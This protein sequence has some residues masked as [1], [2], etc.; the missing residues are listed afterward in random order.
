MCDDMTKPT[1]MDIDGGEDIDRGGPSNQAN[2][3]SA[4]NFIKDGL[5]NACECEVDMFQHAVQCFNCNTYYHA[6]DCSDSSYC[7]SAKTAYTQHIRPALEKTGSYE[8]RFGKFFFMCSSCCTEFELKKVV[9]Q[10]KRVDIIDKKLDNFR[11]ELRSE[12]SDLKKFIMDS[13]KSVIPISDNSNTLSDS[14]T[15]SSS[16]MENCQNP[17]NYPARTKTLFS[18]KVLVVKKSENSGLSIDSS[19]LRKTCVDNG[20]QVSKSFSTSKDEIGLVVNSDQA[21]KTLVDKLKISAPDHKVQD[22]PSKSPTINV[23]GV[24]NEITKENLKHEIFQQNPTIKKLNSDFSGQGEGK[25][26]ILS[27]SKLK[28]N[29]ELSKA[30]IGVSNTIR[31]YIS[32]GCNDR[33]YLGNGTCKVYDSFHVRRCFNCQKYGHISE[34]C[35]HPFSCGYCAGSHE[36]RNCQLKNS[37]TQA[38]ACCSNCKNSTITEQKENCEHPAYSPDCPILKTEQEKMKRSIPFYLRK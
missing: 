4:P 16:N 7:V 15:V 11:N 35:D 23:V 29:Q 9:T 14:A 37:S 36:T 13:N 20:I 12:L 28:N 18:E 8:N 19:L 22:L 1:S 34:K 30:T 33:I 27:I 25:F 17:W 38:Q 5:C 32:K 26:I 3:S 21:A 2:S 31:D 6:V 24:P 10:D